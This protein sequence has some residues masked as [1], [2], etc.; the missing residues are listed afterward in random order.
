MKINDKIKTVVFT[1]FIGILCIIG[2]IY[3]N[4][5]VLSAKQIYEVFIDGK[6]VGY[7]EDDDKLYEI[8]NTKQKEIKNKYNVSKVYPPED[9]KI[10]QTSSYDVILS[11]PEQIYN[12]MA[13]IGS[14]TIEGYIISYKKGD[15]QITINVL[16]KEVFDSAI[17]SFVLA[18]IGEDEY[19]NYMN[20]TQ[21]EIETTG[22]VIKNMYFDE[23][24]NIKKGY[25]S[26]NDT[27]FVDESSLTQYLLFGP[28]NKI[29]K[30]T[31]KEGDTIDSIS[32]VNKLNYKEFL[33]ANPKYSSKDSL[34]TIGDSVN[35]TLINPMLTFIYEVNEVLDTEIAY[36]KKVEYDSSKSADFNE[37]TTAGV[38]GITRIDENYTVKNGQTQGGVEILS[39]VTIK[40]KVDQVTTKGG[41]RYSGGWTTGS[42]KDTGT[43]W[44][45]PTNQPSVLTSG[46]EWRWGS[47]HDGI[48]ISGTGCGSPIYAVLDGE[49]VSSQYGGMVGSA[50]GYNVVIRHSN[51]YYSVYAHMIANSMTVK[52][53]DQV[54][55]GQVIGQM[56]NTGVS[57]GCHCHLGIFYGQPYSGGYS[58]NPLSVYR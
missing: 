13:E 34:L 6:S 29:E 16:D 55:R 27:I 12:K 28:D 10:I 36:E 26:V 3:D 57:Y 53:G 9:F 18:F 44:G 23:I 40:E 48:D 8:I 45:W 39:S 46:Y 1:I 50:S 38:T 31:V 30:Y 24:I 2:F 32:E 58:I 25:I 22:K 56:G 35:I 49:V 19:T 51:G 37:I 21:K 33:V 43:T 47:F 15:K 11:T 52:V 20:N 17:H 7:L 54:V 4:N 42:Y 14:F 5:D 41:Y